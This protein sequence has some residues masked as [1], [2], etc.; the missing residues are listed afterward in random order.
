MTSQPFLVRPDPVPTLPQQADSNIGLTE[1]NLTHNKPDAS[2]WNAAAS[3]AFGQPPQRPLSTASHLQ[4]PF[5]VSSS[6]GSYELLSEYTSVDSYTTVP[7]GTSQ[8]PSTSSHIA[9]QAG[10][11]TSHKINKLSRSA[12]GRSLHNFAGSHTP[13]QSPA[14]SRMKPANTTMYSCTFC[15]SPS[16]FRSKHEWKR[17]ERSHV[18]QVEYTCLPK[19]AL[20]AFG[21]HF[22]CAICGIREPR[23][24]HMVE[25]KMHLCLYKPTEDRTYFRK[26]KFAKHLQV[27]GLSLESPQVAPWGQ[28]IPERVLGCGFCVHYF[29]KFEERAQ[30]VAFHFEQGCRKESWDRS[31]VISSLLARPFVAS[32]WL[33]LHSS[34]SPD[35]ISAGVSWSDS[36]STDE[37]QRRLENDVDNGLDLA[38]AAYNLSSL[39]PGGQ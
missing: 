25:H 21:D 15:N 14:P 4:P 13:S 29:D 36:S 3:R 33:S 1:D 35:A 2:S 24:D 31:T 32:H 6:P 19:G 23:E 34:N 18:P 28:L 20:I 39:C 9:L 27:H 30:H 17:H 22:V 38:V 12:S 16:T 11:N 7:H 5:D 8:H 10:T 37:L 26:D